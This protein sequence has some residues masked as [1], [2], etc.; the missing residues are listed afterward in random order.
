M[1]VV[2]V[3]FLTS[4]HASTQTRYNNLV[5]NPNQNCICIYTGHTTLIDIYT[6]SAEQRIKVE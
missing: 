3:G 6:G 5:E 4:Q 2:F 1:Q